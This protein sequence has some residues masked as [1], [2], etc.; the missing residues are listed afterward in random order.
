MNYTERRPTV[1]GF[2]WVKYQT[3]DT[4]P[5]IDLVL[6]LVLR[7]RPEP[8]LFFEWGEDLL[9]VGDER[10]KA[11]SGPLAKPSIKDETKPVANPR[12]EILMDLL[13][14]VEQLGMDS[15]DD[16]SAFRRVRAELT[17]LVNVG[18]MEGEDPGLVSIEGISIS[19]F[20]MMATSDH[21]FTSDRTLKA[22][23]SYEQ[24]LARAAVEDT[25]VA[26][27]KQAEA[28]RKTDCRLEVAGAKNDGN[29]SRYFK[30]RIRIDAAP[31]RGD[32]FYFDGDVDCY[33][34][35][36][37]VDWFLMGRKA[38]LQIRLLVENAFTPVDESY[39]LANEWVECDECMKPLEVR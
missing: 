20:L 15:I 39:L 29:G 14:R 36:E 11:F 5:T 18:K 23:S 33:A 12:L 32:L 27:A 3:D 26:L 21:A 10:M 7:Q 2:Y 22:L 19:N 1:P 6:E 17:S 37:E 38:A 34:K 24:A 16:G 9:L 8:Q 28:D 30:N 13:E 25:K 35:V 31:M 4:S